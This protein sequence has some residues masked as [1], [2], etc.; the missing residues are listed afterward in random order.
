MRLKSCCLRRL[1]IKIE[2]KQYKFTMSCNDNLNAMPPGSP[3]SSVAC[4]TLDG[5]SLFDKYGFDDGDL[6]IDVLAEFRPYEAKWA[7]IKGERHEWC[8]AHSV[9][10]TVVQRYLLVALPRPLSVTVLG[11]AHNPIRA[12]AAE[13]D[14]DIAE[15]EVSVPVTEIHQLARQLLG[16]LP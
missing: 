11:T 1:P 6:L 4:I 3:S 16:L 2:R 14:W 13:L 15:V 10:V 5:Y 7:Q 8:F 9:L 12:A